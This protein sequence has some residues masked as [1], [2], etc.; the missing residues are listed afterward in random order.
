MTTR[1]KPLGLNPQC[2]SVKNLDGGQGRFG[3]ILVGLPLPG[4]AVVLL[5]T[6]SDV[7]PQWRTQKNL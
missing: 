1:I 4:L 7:L 3:F 2:I 5:T 6:D